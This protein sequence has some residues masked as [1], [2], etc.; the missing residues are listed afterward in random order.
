ALRY[1][2]KPGDVRRT[3]TT[4]V[5]GEEAGDIHIAHRTYDV[6]VW[7]IPEA[8][9][10]LTDIRALPID[11]PR[12]GYVRLED[13][14]DVRVAPTPNVVEHDNLKRRLDVRADV[15]GRDLGSVVA[16]VVRRLQE[17][18][19]PLGY[20]PQLIGEFQERQAAQRS[21]LI[22][23]VVSMIGIFLILQVSFGS[24]RLA[25]LSFLTLPS[26]LV[27]G[28][29]AAYFSDG[30]ISL[31]SLVGFLTILGIAARNGIMLIDHFQHL[32][33]YEGET[34]GPAL[35]LRGARERIS[36]IMMT[37]L[38]SALAIMPLVAAGSIPGHEIEH[39]LAVV[40]LGGLVTS[41]LLNLF[42][43]PSLYLRFGAS[44]EPD[45]SSV[46]A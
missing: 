17:V 15:R 24:W 37:A 39:P 4:L 36:P 20:Y 41:T 25:T 44:R 26:A 31:G 30:V 28:V 27:G 18:E 8:R 19:F 21:I 46:Q 22:V 11:T 12:G 10:S 42:V 34:F 38:T 3:A 23:S 13:V 2:I 45:A 29:L 32:Q 7:S 43:V 16:D 1:G 6:N 33:R 35:V 40:V 14:A 5:A 9:N